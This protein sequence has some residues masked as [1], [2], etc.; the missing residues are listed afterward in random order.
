M[1][2]ARVA[3]PP[4]ERSL[5]E[6]IAVATFSDSYTHPILRVFFFV[7]EILKLKML[8]KINIYFKSVI[9]FRFLML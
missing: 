5:S 7:I 4:R 6:Q 2:V 3:G 1:W 8:Q 9:N